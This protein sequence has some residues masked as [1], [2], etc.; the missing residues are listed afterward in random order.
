MKDFFGFN[1]N[2]FPS[3]HKSKKKNSS[4]DMFGGK[5]GNG[6]LFGLE[7][8]GIGNIMDEPIFSNP[9]GGQR[10][11]QPVMFVPVM[12][13]QQP[14]FLN[15]DF[16]S[17]FQKHSVSGIKPFT[18]ENVAMVPNEPG[19]YEFF[20]DMYNRLYVGVSD[21]LRHRLQSYYQD[22][23]FNEH[24]TKASLR[25]NIRFFKIRL[26]PIERAREIEHELKTETPHNH[27]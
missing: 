10:K 18:K 23:D 14:T 5:P 12:Q 3:S 25:N 17:N 9:I 21:V 7:D 1:R 8:I 13:N 2:L 15:F 11:R 22:D 24:P 16:N 20:D 26:M 4:P 6:D 27:N 19:V